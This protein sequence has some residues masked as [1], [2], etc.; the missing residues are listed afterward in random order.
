MSKILI[1]SSLAALALAI[2]PAA[3]ARSDADTQAIV[4]KF[5]VDA[6]VKHDA[7]AAAAEMSQNFIEHHPPQ[8]APERTRAEFLAMVARP[9]R[10]PPGGGPASGPPPPDLIQVF[11]NYVLFM[12]KMQL[13]DPT[14]P[15][16]KYD[17]D[18]FD[19][20][21]VDAAGKVAEHWDS[22]TKRAMPAAGPP[23]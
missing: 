20:F 14:A 1:R 9:M 15:G 8:G 2:A 4:M 10:A 12:T 6:F 16:S 23:A 22:G 21:R 11:G 7:K 3:F 17:A 18:W 13:P 19:L 5:N